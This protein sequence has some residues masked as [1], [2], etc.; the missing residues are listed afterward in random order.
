MTVRGGGDALVL[1]TG[2][3]PHVLFANGRRNVARAVLS[4]NALEALVTQIFT[5]G[6]R[7]T[8]LDTDHVVEQVTVRDAGLTLTARAQRTPEHITIELRQTAEPAAESALPVTAAF[9][10]EPE[11]VAIDSAEKGDASRWLDVPLAASCDELA[12]NAP[13][14]PSTEHTFLAS[15]PENLFPDFEE[16]SVSVSPDRP[17][18][19]PPDVLL[20][21]PPSTEAATRRPVS[22]SPRRSAWRSPTGSCSA[23][24]AAARPCAT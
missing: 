14:W 10:T 19:E 17:L 3:S 8:L 9:D 12:L 1:R 6:G 7:Q 22:R 21:A 2:E 15:A 16:S 4:A 24:A 13:G 5:A 20:V 23:L 11:R 18:A